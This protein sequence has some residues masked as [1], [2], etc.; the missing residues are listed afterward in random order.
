[1]AQP[2][3]PVQPVNTDVLGPASNRISR[4]WRQ[5]FDLLTAIVNGLPAGGVAPAD[6]TYVVAS[7]NATLTAERVATTTTSITVDT[8]TAGQMQ[9]KRA[10]LTGD[11]TASADSNATTIANDAVTFAKMQEIATQRAIGRNTAGTG[12]PEEVTIS[13]ML[14][15]TA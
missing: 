8:A 5:F 9:W 6:A 2:P 3:I 13:Q 7:A 12:N 10:A 11:V 1:M 15:W 4:P 14:D